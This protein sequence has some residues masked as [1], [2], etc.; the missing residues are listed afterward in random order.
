MLSEALR[1]ANIGDGVGEPI[2]IVFPS[3][4]EMPESQ[5]K[6]ELEMEQTLNP[7]AHGRCRFQGT[8]L[9]LEESVTGSRRETPR[10][11]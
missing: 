8:R 5:A 1:A 6:A 7:Y 2:H 9:A 11:F 4:V 10:S 3:R